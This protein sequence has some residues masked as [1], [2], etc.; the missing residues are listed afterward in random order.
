MTQLI[1]PG[2]ALLLGSMLASSVLAA[3]STPARALLALSKRDRTLAIIDPMSLKI[4]AKVPVGPDP[5]EV[6][7]GADGRFAYVSDYGG[8]AY[9]ILS[10]VDLVQQKAL[11]PIDLGPL[12]GP[13][14][15]A[16]VGGKLW[17]TAEGAKV[18][19]SYN[20]N[21]RRVDWILGTGQDRT[22]M[23]YVFPDLK[24]MVTSNVSSG[25]MSIIEATVRRGFGPPSGVPPAPPGA[26]PGGPPPGVRPGFPQKDWEET[27]VKVGGGAEGFD[28]SPDGREIWAGNAQDG[29]ISIIDL[30]SKKVTETLAANVRG[31]NR[32]KFTPDGKQ[33]FVSSLSN[34]DL[35]IFDAASRREVKRVKLGRGAAG[36]LMDPDGSRAFVA[37]SPD[38]YVAVID[39][40]T[41]EVT[42]RFE[43]GNDPDGLAWAI[44]R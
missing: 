33:V 24:R 9:H 1:R 5:H 27:V 37:C 25:T 8:G 10:V 14:G 39:L 43:P 13:H 15:L 16:F 2:W 7:A 22:H 4:V 20:P 17:F 34:S 3:E 26:G 23:I 44:R 36:I 31:A 19:G 28:I 18:I 40:K 38:N 41:L 30:A 42:G 11:P 21:L 35:A 29:T 12:G 32:L 6:I